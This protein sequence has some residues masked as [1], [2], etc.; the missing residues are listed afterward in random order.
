MKTTLG[1]RKPKPKMG[2]VPTVLALF[3]KGR[4]AFNSSPKSVPR[5]GLRIGRESSDAS[6]IS[7]D[8]GRVSR[9]HAMVL[10]QRGDD[11][12]CL[13]D[14]GSRNGTFLNGQQVE[15]ALIVDGDVVRVGDSFLLF[16]L[17]PVRT[18]DAP[19]RG[20]LGQSPVIREIRDTIELVGPT[21]AAVIL[22]GG[23]GTG[24]GVVARAL[25]EAS[26]RTGP[27]V[28]VNCSA[29]PENLAESQLF[30]HVAGAFTGAHK[31]HVGWFR[32][33]H[34]GT[35]F[36]DEV[37]DLSLVLQPKLLVALEEQSVTPV[38]SVKPVS[39]DIRLIAAT[40]KDLKSSIQMERFRGDLYSRLSEITINMPA[41]NQRR[42]DI[43]LLLSENLPLRSQRLDPELVEALFL[44]SWP[45]NVRELFKVTKELV[46]R[47]GDKDEL[48]LDLV[49][50]RLV[51]LKPA[52]GPQSIEEVLPETPSPPEP[53]ER[54]MVPSR[55]QLVSLLKEHRGVI[56]DIAR[57]E[58]RSRKQVYRWLRKRGLRAEDFRSG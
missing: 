2:R 47:G 54:A 8:D 23:T 32:S 43:L 56:A 26:D 10:P 4:V 41:L 38:G 24:K 58:G 14:S 1:P 46:I 52:E 19:E 21:D 30:G 49:R 55:E 17:E 35:L 25:H 28:S 34:L 40:N 31:D 7:L 22:L 15:R 33:A 53:S 36:L 39:C 12:F 48:D 18:T 5:Q 20:L 6:G 3:T 50:E 9:Q 27:F 29:I 16:R 51:D 11:S 13:L 42:E 44:Y 37:A 45:Y 57:A